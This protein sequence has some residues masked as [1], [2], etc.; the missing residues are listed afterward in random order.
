MKRAFTLIEL[1]VVIIII[2]LLS[3]LSMV[4]F[5]SARAK[6]RDTR[7]IS[8]ITQ[9][10]TALEMYHSR[11]GTYPPTLVANNSLATPSGLVVFAKVPS[12]P[13]GSNGYEYEYMQTKDGQG[14]TIKFKLETDGGKYVAGGYQATPQGVFVTVNEE[15][16]D[17]GDTS[18]WTCG[19]LLVD[20]KD[21]NTYTT[22]ATSEGKC[23]MTQS[24]KR[25]TSQR[26]CF[27]D[28]PDNCERYG[29]LYPY[30]ANICPNGWHLFSS[31]DRDR[32]TEPV[33]TSTEQ[34]GFI[35]FYNTHDKT[36]ESNPAGLIMTANRRHFLTGGL[37]IVYWPENETFPYVSVRCIKD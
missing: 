2:V 18:T 5:N 30:N 14:Y 13:L 33:I 22:A 15:S 25:K 12:D 28:D 36:Y 35:G 1:L 3:T 21:G 37:E 4:A 23:V 6:S 7:R 17:G 32:Y 24:L 9:M 8:D 20:K 29:G 34:E 19:D 31:D 27:N 26:K 11:V 16:G 10:R